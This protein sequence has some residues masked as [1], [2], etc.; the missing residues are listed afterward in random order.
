LLVFLASGICLLEPFE[1]VLPCLPSFFF[2]SSHCHFPQ[3]PPLDLARGLESA[4]VA[5][6]GVW[7]DRVGSAKCDCCQVTTAVELLWV[8]S[9]KM[10]ESKKAFDEVCLHY[11]NISCLFYVYNT[12]IAERLLQEFPNK[13]DILNTHFIQN[14]SLISHTDLFFC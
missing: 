8:I 10:E 4:V 7:V 1:Q 12:S 5:P 6:G 11:A 9:C 3:G 14:C 13:A 2:F